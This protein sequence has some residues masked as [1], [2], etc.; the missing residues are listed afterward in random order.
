MIHVVG[1]LTRSLPRGSPFGLPA[2]VARIATAPLCKTPMARRPA[3][4]P[5]SAN[6]TGL[7]Y[8]KKIVTKF[9]ERFP[10]VQSS[11]ET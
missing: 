8:S 2:R 11:H 1:R 9:F 4:T 6:V 10:F 5:Y 3:Q 7:P